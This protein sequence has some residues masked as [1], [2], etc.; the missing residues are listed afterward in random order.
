MNGTLGQNDYLLLIC[1][2]KATRGLCYLEP[3]QR[4]RLAFVSAVLLCTESTAVAAVFTAGG[5]SPRNVL[6]QGRLFAGRGLHAAYTILQCCFCVLVFQ[7]SRA[8]CVPATT[9]C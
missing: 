6:L 7:F 8:T 3:R 1:I 9:A 2:V 4:K 5:L